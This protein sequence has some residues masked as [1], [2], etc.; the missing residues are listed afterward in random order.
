[1]KLEFVEKKTK[2]QDGKRYARESYS[3]GGYAV[4]VDDTFYPDGNSVHDISLQVIVEDEYLP[5]IYFRAGWFGQE[6]TFEIQT[7]SYG[8]LKPTEFTK[9]LMAQQKAMKVV[10]VLTKEFIEEDC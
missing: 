2:D 9:F 4:Y 5:N 10:E 3:I 6:P 1:M 7:T 8:P